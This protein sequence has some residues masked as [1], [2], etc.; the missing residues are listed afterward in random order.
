[1]VIKDFF[2]VSYQKTIDSN[3]K[4]TLKQILDLKG[5]HYDD[6]YDTFFIYNVGLS[7]VSFKTNHVEYSL[8]F[9]QPII[10]DCY[11]DFDKYL[12]M[13]IKEIIEYCKLLSLY[14]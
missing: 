13:S 9:Q 5:N 2:G 7:V 8:R 4:L 14:S 12:S 3:S 6:P 1:M 11:Y 10:V